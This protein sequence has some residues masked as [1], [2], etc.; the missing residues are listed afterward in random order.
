MDYVV[1]IPSYARAETL[2]EKTIALLER[3]KIPK[4]KIYIFVANKEEEKVY[5]EH[6]KD[7]KIVVGVKGLLEQRNFMT[8]YFKEGQKIVY[9]DDD[10]EDVYVKKSADK[11]VK[12]L[13]DL[14]L[15]SFFPV[16]FKTLEKENLYIW[17][18][19]PVLNAYFLYQS[20]S[21]DLRYIIGAFYGVINRH[22][23]DIL[24]KLQSEKEDVER[25]LRYYKKDGGV[26]RFNFITIK[27]K[28]YAPG[29]IAAEYGTKEKRLAESKGAVQ[30]LLK[31][32]PE[33]G[34]MKTRPSGIVEF[35]F[36]RNPKLKGGAATEDALTK[37]DFSVRKLPIRNKAKYDAAK[38]FFLEE[39]EKVT[40]PKIRRS[41]YDE[42]GNVIA[43]ERDLTIGTIGR[44]TNFGFL[45]TRTRGYAPAVANRDYPDLFEA[46]VQLG[47]QVVPKGWKYSTITLNYGVKAKKHIDKLNVGDS[48]IVGVGDYTGGGLYT[49]KPNGTDPTLHNIKDHPAMFNGALVPHKTEAF[50]GE[51]YTLIFFSMKEGASIPGVSMIG[52]GDAEQEDVVDAGVTA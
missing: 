33:Y 49:Y 29:G 30:R 42:K 5:K 43:P 22:D 48:V 15:K 18:V 7:Y 40:I 16:A 32:F 3:N 8:K 19:N 20:V 35:V 36:K 52:K 47:N 10:I 34:T 23:K 24:L 13:E 41:R 9:M 31:E 28:F 51:R 17:G 11:K 26:L 37:Q 39:V 27:T 44:T 21:K 45:K 4:E 6:L 46:I 1:A 14:P 38:K 25:T 50:K 12:K 2:K